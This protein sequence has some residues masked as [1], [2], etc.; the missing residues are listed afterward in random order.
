[1]SRIELDV[2]IYCRSTLQDCT[3]RDFEQNIDD[4][5]HFDVSRSVSHGYIEV[6]MLKQHHDFDVNQMTIKANPIICH[7]GMRFSL[8]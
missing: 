5:F 4:Y 6:L 1:M 2:S 3:G 8:S 7:S